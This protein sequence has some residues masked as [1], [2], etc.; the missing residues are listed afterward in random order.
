MEVI[1]EDWM[2]HRRSDRG[3]ALAA[4]VAA[5]GLAVSGCGGSG[6]AENAGTELQAEAVTLTL[7]EGWD[8]IHEL[9]EDEYDP[10]VW[11][12]T[13]ADSETDP[14]GHIRILPQFD[15]PAE[16]DAS[17]GLFLGHVTGSPDY[18]T[19]MEPVSQQMLDIDGADGFE[20]Q[21]ED[22]ATGEGAVEDVEGR[23]WIMADQGSG[24][25]SVVEFLGF[26][27]P[28]FDQVL[29]SIEFDPGAADS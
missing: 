21:F 16:A 24:V 6:A 2:I 17:A 13:A 14:T 3:I 12:V 7:P 19:D 4:L 10:R 29:Q 1:E 23:W 9:S 26:E 8:V 18:G 28:D 11:V 5:T 25:V 27:D 15:G 20:I 22:P